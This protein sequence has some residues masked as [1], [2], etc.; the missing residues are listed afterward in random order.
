MKS[1]RATDSFMTTRCNTLLHI[2][3]TT[4]ADHMG[5]ITKPGVEVKFP[6]LQFGRTRPYQPG[7]YRASVDIN[8]KYAQ[9]YRL[10]QQRRASFRPRNNPTR[11]SW[12][13]GT[14]TDGQVAYFASIPQTPLITAETKYIYRKG[15]PAPQSPAKLDYTKSWLQTT[16][17]KHL[18]GSLPSEET[19]GE[20]IHQNSIAE[21]PS[22]SYS[23]SS[24]IPEPLPDITSKPQ[25]TMTMKD[26]FG[27]KL[28]TFLTRYGQGLTDK[29]PKVIS[30]TN[31]SRKLGTIVSSQRLGQLLNN[32]LPLRLNNF[33]SSNKKLR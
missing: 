29:T 15:L 22:S 20:Y 2:N 13:P 12:P 17:D 9:H 16:A 21:Y 33:Y 19:Q 1:V 8:R 28:Q 10:V 25:E 24:V 4:L 18:Y 27:E 30:K 31:H 11:Q 7:G 14:G 23:S 32:D 5:R 3:P 26:S 6:Q